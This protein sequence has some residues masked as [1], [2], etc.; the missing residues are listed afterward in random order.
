MA[1]FNLTIQLQLRAPANLAQVGKQIS[2][3]LGATPVNIPV[4]LQVPP[5]SVSQVLQQAQQQAQQASTA[6]NNMAR[7]AT[8]ATVAANN[9]ATAQARVNLQMAQSRLLMTNM[10]RQV[11]TLNQQVLQGTSYWARFGAAVSD[12]SQR[13][14]AFVAGAS[15]FLVV[16]RGIREGV[17]AAIEFE[18]QINKIAQ[19]SG[20]SDAAI[21]GIRTRIGELAQS[22]GVSSTEMSQ[23]AL[24][25]AQTGLTAKEVAENMETLAMAA[26]APNFESMQQ[27]A[28]GMIAVMRQFKL[29]SVGVKESIGAMNEV[30]A[31]FA[32][33]SRDLVTAVRKAGGAFAAAGG[34][35]NELLALFTAVR[36]TT[37][38]GAEEIA[39]G[40]RTIL[41]RTQRADVIEELRALNV[42]LR[43]TAK[44]ADAVGRSD[45]TN[46]FVGPY[47]AVK[48]LSEAIKSI[49]ATDPR[50]SSVVESLG[51]YRQISRVIPLI[52]QF[53]TAEK[54]LATAQVG[55]FS[56]YRSAEKAQESLYMKVARTREEFLELFRA[57]SETPAF[58]MFAR[59]ALSAA[60][61]VGTLL[62]TLKPLLPMLLAIGTVKLAQAFGGFVTRAISGPPAVSPKG[63]ARGGYVDGPAGHGDV[64]PARLS[65][66][67]FVVREPSVRALRKQFGDS[68]LPVI[69]ET[70]R[71][72]RFEGG[73]RPEEDP[74]FVAEMLRGVNQVTRTRK[75]GV[76]QVIG[77]MPLDM[78]MGTA[79]S[80]GLYFVNSKEELNQRHNY[81]RGHRDYP[82]HARYSE[83]SDYDGFSAQFL[84][85]RSGHVILPNKSRMSLS[86]A[87]DAIKFLGRSGILSRAANNEMLGAN[88]NFTGLVNNNSVLNEMNFRE[89]G[90][91]YEQ[92]LQYIVSNLHNPRQNNSIYDMFAR[93]SVFGSGRERVESN[94]LI[95]RMLR[96]GSSSGSYSDVSR[97]WL[98][99][100]PLR[101]EILGHADGGQVSPFK[102]MVANVLMGLSS[103]FGGDPL[104]DQAELIARKQEEQRR[105]QVQV[106]SQLRPPVIGKAMGGQI[107]RFEG[108]GPASSSLDDIVSNY[109]RGLGKK[110]NI[111]LAQYANPGQ[112]VSLFQKINVPYYGAY[113]PT[114]NS[115]AMNPAAIGQSG[116]LPPA[117]MYTATH[118]LG[119]LIDYNRDRHSGTSPFNTLRKLHRKNIESLFEERGISIF[120]GNPNN[121]MDLQPS[122]IDKLN[123][124]DEVMADAIAFASSRLLRFP[125]RQNMPHAQSLKSLKRMLPELPLKGFDDVTNH[126]YDKVVPDIRKRFGEYDPT[127]RYEDGGMAQSLIAGNALIV[128]NIRGYDREKNLL[129]IS[130]IGNE[131]LERGMSLKWHQKKVDAPGMESLLSNHNEFPFN[132]STLKN[133]L[134]TLEGADYNELM[135]DLKKRQEIEIRHYIKGVGDEAN[136]NLSPFVQPYGI[137]LSIGHDGPDKTRNYH[138]RMLSSIPLKLRNYIPY[139]QQLFGISLQNSSYF[140]P[141]GQRGYERASL[142]AISQNMTRSLNLLDTSNNPEAYQQQRGFDTDVWKYRL[143]RKYLIGDSGINFEHKLARNRAIGLS[144]DYE[145]AGLAEY[146][147]SDKMP[148]FDEKQGQQLYLNPKEFLMD[149]PNFRKVRG[150][151]DKHRNHLREI[152]ANKQQHLAFF[153]SLVGDASGNIPKLAT[154]GIVNPV[155]LKEQMFAQGGDS[156]DRIPA[157]VTPGEFIVREE[158]ARNLYPVLHYMN[159]YGKV[160]PHLLGRDGKLRGYS[161]GGVVGDPLVREGEDLTKIDPTIIRQRLEDRNKLRGNTQ[162]AK[163]DL[164]TD[165]SELGL[166]DFLA[167][168]KLS[169]KKGGIASRGKDKKLANVVDDIMRVVTLRHTNLDEF[170]QERARVAAIKSP[171]RGPKLRAA[172]R[173]AMTPEQKQEADAQVTSLDA[174]LK[175]YQGRILKA[176]RS[177]LLRY[178][179]NDFSEEDISQ[180]AQILAREKMA[181]GQFDKTRGKSKDPEGAYLAQLARNLATGYMK[182]NYI[183]TNEDLLDERGV[184]VLTRNNTPRKKWVRR[185]VS[186]ESTEEGQT[187]VLDAGA[188]ASPQS[189]LSSEFE[190][191]TPEQ[192]EKEKIEQ[193]A[194]QQKALQL[195]AQKRAENVARSRNAETIA[196][197]IYAQASNQGGQASTQGAAAAMMAAR[198]QKAEALRAAK[199]AGRVE[200]SVPTPAPVILPT[201]PTGPGAITLANLLKPVSPPSPAPEAYLSPSSYGDGDPLMPYPNTVIRRPDKKLLSIAPLNSDGEPINELMPHPAE[202]SQLQAMIEQERRTARGFTG[203]SLPIIR[204]PL[205]KRYEG[206][207]GQVDDY[208]PSRNLPVYSPRKAPLKGPSE[209]VRHGWQSGSIA[210]LEDSQ[211]VLSASG[212]GSSIPP[213]PPTPPAPPPPPGDEP[214][215]PSFAKFPLPIIRKSPTK[216]YEGLLGQTDDR[217]L[218]RIPL[219][220]LPS[221]SSLPLVRA[222][223]PIT[224]DA[225]LKAQRGS[226][227]QAS[228]SYLTSQLPPT[229]LSS[230]V[231]STDEELAVAQAARERMR[232]L[233]K[234]QIENKLAQRR[235]DSRRK[236]AQNLPYPSGD[237]RID[238]LKFAAGNEEFAKYMNANRT[239]ISKQINEKIKPGDT[240]RKRRRSTMIDSTAPPV[241]LSKAIKFGEDGDLITFSNKHASITS[242]LIPGPTTSE[243]SPVVPLA[244]NPSRLE[245]EDFGRD[246]W[247]QESDYFDGN[248]PQSPVLPTKKLVPPAPPLP[249]VPPTTVPP[250]PVPAPSPSF[251]RGDYRHILQPQPG[252]L[253]KVPSNARVAKGKVSLYGGWY[254]DAPAMNA[255]DKQRQRAGRDFIPDYTTETLAGPLA[256]PR[257]IRPVMTTPEVMRATQQQRLP[258]DISSK[259]LAGMEEASASIARQVR[260]SLYGGQSEKAKKLKEKIDNLN[261]KVLPKLMELRKAEAAGGDEKML[262]KLDAAIENAKLE[263]TK[264][265][266]KIPVANIEAGGMMAV[267]ELRKQIGGLGGRQRVNERLEFAQARMRKYQEDFEG[268]SSGDVG[269]DAQKAKVESASKD[270]QLR[271]QQKRQ[272]EQVNA[273]VQRRQA[274]LDPLRTARNQARRIA[275][276]GVS[277][278]PALSP[279][280]QAMDVKAALR[281]QNRMAGTANVDPL[282]LKA[283]LLRQI[284][285]G[286]AGPDT[287]EYALDQAK[288]YDPKKRTGLSPAQYAQIAKAYEKKGGVLSHDQ[289][290]KSEGAIDTA[291]EAANRNPVN[292]QRARTAGAR[293]NQAGARTSTLFELMEKNARAE[294]GKEEKEMM[295]RNGGQLSQTTRDE[296]HNKALPKAAEKTQRDLINAQAQVLQQLN[297]EL[298]SGEAYRMAREQVAEALRK[299]A[300]QQ[301]AAAQARAEGKT[302][303]KVESQVALDKNGDPLGLK[304]T[305]AQANAQ[306]INVGPVKP[307][308]NKTLG[309]ILDEKTDAAAKLVLDKKIA[310][311]AGHPLSQRTQDEAKNQARAN[312]SKDFMRDLQS[313]QTEALLVKKKGM[314]RNEAEQMAREQIEAA[315]R[316]EAAAAQH[317]QSGAEGPPP[318]VPRIVMGTNGKPLGLEDTINEMQATGAVPPGPAPLTWSERLGR[319]G[320]TVGQGL[321]N[322]VTERE[323]RWQAA[324]ARNG[325]NPQMAG[326]GFSMMAPYLGQAFQGDAETAVLAQRGGTY[327]AGA[328]TSGAL[329]GAAVGAM[330]GS[331]LPGMG[332]QGMVGGAALGAII[333]GFTAFRE[334]VR[335]LS[336]IKLD[337]AIGM[338]ADKLGVLAA[339]AENP[340]A[341]L[342]YRTGAIQQMQTAEDEARSM[343]EEGSGYL[344]IDPKKYAALREKAERQS[345]GPL[346]PSMIQTLQGDISRRLKTDPDLKQDGK[347]V[348][349]VAGPLL[350]KINSD[351]LD[352]KIIDRLANLKKESPQN[353]LDEQKIYIAKQ[354]RSLQ[355]EDTGKAAQR[356]QESNI[357]SFGLMANA[358]QA[359]SDSLRLLRNSAN[360]LTEAF[361][362]NLTNPSRVDINPDLLGK[363]GTG[364]P[365]VAPLLELFKNNG[366]ETGR[367]MYDTATAADRI[368][369]ELP[370]ALLAAAKT[371]RQDTDEGRTDFMT[372]VRNQMEKALG[373]Q[374][375][376]GAYRRVLD[377]S[378]ASVNQM[379]TGEKQ[380]QGLLQAVVEDASGVGRRATEPVLGPI[381]EYGRKFLEPLLGGVNEYSERLATGR[382]QGEVTFSGEIRASEM[383]LS[384]QRLRA[385]VTGEQNLTPRASLN[386]ISLAQLV[387][388]FT[389]RQA[390]LAQRAGIGG[391]G[392]SPD[393]FAKKYKELTP[394]ILA[395]QEAQRSAIIGGNPGEI[396]ATTKRLDEL[397]GQAQNAANGLRSL[398]ES[399]TNLQAIQEKI[400]QIRGDKEGRLGFAERYVTSGVEGRLE[401]QRGLLLFGQLAAKDSRTKPS[402][403]SLVPEDQALV[404]QT[405]R[406]LGGTRLSGVPGKPYASDKLQEL[407][408]NSMG[409]VAGLD[410]ESSKEMENL[411]GQ[412]L[413]EQ[414]NM[415]E[416]QQLTVKL[417]KDANKEL[418][419]GIDTFIASLFARLSAFFANEQVEA[420]EKKIIVE[421]QRQGRLVQQ[422]SFADTLAGAGITTDLQQRVVEQ[423]TGDLQQ[424]S[425]ARVKTQQII[426]NYDKALNEIQAGGYTPFETNKSTKVNMEELLKNNALGSESGNI[427]ESGNSSLFSPEMRYSAI[428][429]SLIAR[430][431]ALKKMIT[432][433]TEG[434][435][436]KDNRSYLGVMYGYDSGVDSRS[437]QLAGD[438][439][440]GKDTLDNAKDVGLD[441][442][443]LRKTLSN[444]DSASKL[445]QAIEGLGGTSITQLN[446]KLEESRKEIEALNVE[447]DRLKANAKQLQYAA[448]PP[449]AVSRDVLPPAG[450]LTNPDVPQ[451]GPA[452]PQTPE[453]MDRREPGN[454]PF[455]PRNPEDIL[456]PRRNPNPNPGALPLPTEVEPTLLPALI[457]A[458]EQAMQLGAAGWSGLGEIPGLLGQIPL[459]KPRPERLAEPPVPVRDISNEEAVDKALALGIGDARPASSL[460]SGRQNLGFE[461][462][463]RDKEKLAL[464]ATGLGG[465]FATRR[466][467][468]IGLPPHYDWTQRADAAGPWTMSRLNG[469][470]I[471]GSGGLPRKPEQLSVAPKIQLPPSLLK[472]NDDDAMRRYI[473]GAFSAADI[474][475]NMLKDDE[476]SKAALGIPGGLKGLNTFTGDY[477]KYANDGFTPGKKPLIQNY[478]KIPDTEQRF[479]ESILERPK[480]IRPEPISEEPVPG[481]LERLKVEPTQIRPEQLLAHPTPQLPYLVRKYY[482]E[483]TGDYKTYGDFRPPASLSHDNKMAHVPVMQVL[484]GKKIRQEWRSQFGTAEQAKDTSWS[485]L[486]IH[487][488]EQW[489]DDS[490][491]YLKEMEKWRA[492]GGVGKKPVKPNPLDASRYN[493]YDS[494]L[495]APGSQLLP[496]TQPRTGVYGGGNGG[497]NLLPSV[498]P[499]AHLPRFFRHIYDEQDPSNLLLNGRTFADEFT[500]AKPVQGLNRMLQ[501][502]SLRSELMAGGGASQRE[503][504]KFL[505]DYKKWKEEGGKSDARPDISNYFSF[506]RGVGFPNN[507]TFPDSFKH[508]VK[509]ADLFAQAGPGGTISALPVE[510]SRFGHEL[511]V[512]PGLRGEIQRFVTDWT[513]SKGT[514]RQKPEINDYF[515]N[516]N[517]RV[518]A[519]PLGDFTKSVNEAK[520]AISGL[521]KEATTTK[522]ALQQVTD[523]VKPK[524]G[525][526]SIRAADFTDTSGRS[527]RSPF[528]PPIAEAKAT[529][530]AEL[531]RGPAATERPARLK[532]APEATLD[533]KEIPAPQFGPMDHLPNFFKHMYD[534]V[535]PAD[536]LSSKT[537]ADEYTKDGAKK[538]LQR[539]MQNPA[540]GRVV[541]A[542]GPLGEKEMGRFLGDYEEW[543]NSQFND[544]ARADYEKKF[545]HTNKPEIGNYFGFA[546]GVA[547]PRSKST[548]AFFREIHRNADIYRHLGPVGTTQVIQ[549]MGNPI[550]SE[551]LGTIPGAMDEVKRFLEDYQKFKQG[552][553]RLPMPEMS[554]Y[555]AVGGAVGHPGSPRGTDTIPAWLTP[556]EFVVNAAS[557]AANRDL[558]EQ[559]NQARGPVYLAEGGLLPAFEFLGQ[560][561]TQLKNFDQLKGQDLASLENQ[562]GKL[563]LPQL[564]SF[565]DMLPGG[566]GSPF[567]PMMESLMPAR[568]LSYQGSDLKR[569]LRMRARMDPFGAAGQKIRGDSSLSYPEMGAQ[570]ALFGINLLRRRQ[571]NAQSVDPFAAFGLAR[572][573]SQSESSIFERA[574]VGRQAGME[575]AIRTNQDARRARR[576]FSLLTNRSSW[577]RHPAFMND[578]R[579]RTPGFGFGFGFASGGFVPSYLAMGGLPAPDNVPAYLSGGEYVLPRKV[580]DNYGLSNVQKFAEGGLVRGN[581]GGIQ[582]PAGQTSAGIAPEVL[583]AISK[584]SQF[585]EMLKTAFAGFS[586]SVNLLRNSLTGFGVAAGELANAL[587]NFSGTLQVSGT[588]R[589]ELVL[590]GADI[591]KTISGDLQKMV[592]DMVRTQVIRLMKQSMPDVNIE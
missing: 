384:L 151:Q 428:R 523:V 18:R 332:I 152:M 276:A 344:S 377:I 1:G 398:A 85:L 108:G 175:D 388:P 274:E 169:A 392:L 456:D 213:V 216:R 353:V 296:L 141:N 592:A 459:S 283:D 488:L 196:A 486:N 584:F 468:Q 187:S 79:F 113:L 575:R 327:T 72:P 389:D 252:I 547:F 463:T 209:V 358:A 435:A 154:G 170:E 484:D 472:L 518:M 577:V 104:D 509:N 118:E 502:P 426:D 31:K 289:M 564:P 541:K 522:D 451:G 294:Y 100:R 114:E 4:R 87:K 226:A 98:F 173:E 120:S 238:T 161:K 67:E 101:P 442:P 228:P 503:M 315:M 99:Q 517:A 53:A 415:I 359:A 281:Q 256:E 70:G 241:S 37:R 174:K 527:V 562:F 3:A 309:E 474:L 307:S 9:Q 511:K 54:A 312:V 395:A 28:E 545:G 356:G 61:A 97:E 298:K 284:E 407:L 222:T 55:S 273:E 360:N 60:S 314:N 589:V 501:I 572:P 427:L 361:E 30:A 263:V 147:L 266:A 150:G 558:L 498:D 262:E 264:S 193:A 585:S 24:I 119:H 394:Q 494:P 581:T 103:F 455:A 380:L 331:Y 194:I 406:S 259:E 440:K 563:S 299:E 239:L 297:R 223:L 432:P 15:A 261:K 521:S 219:S 425:A 153:R 116:Q 7:S 516:P 374:A 282:K 208:G 552:G 112:F 520:T 68:F 182:H 162:Y 279:A 249:P 131:M 574:L 431:D 550:F 271:Q 32:V 326:F 293:F 137:P 319:F 416:A 94:K 202:E 369:D 25:L 155:P 160:P 418:L 336:Q 373:E 65:A 253:G 96:V 500:D 446:A 251:P 579:M 467:D 302:V 78:F 365:E 235:S 419:A 557:A 47:E 242:P 224:L 424:Y 560:F 159:R 396:Q 410:A 106:V 290:T 91:E 513:S 128:P 17:G 313:A 329:Q 49:P 382:R 434:E 123:D 181:A 133:N 269:Y 240:P 33:E 57:I 408:L 46:Q 231:S 569:E 402:L 75:S 386:A 42:E 429:G 464:L 366:G 260:P 48:R 487:A 320:R 39:T 453:R 250:S 328:T 244:A 478:L 588:Q 217:R 479:A 295:A 556:N 14:G 325:F 84:G 364:N 409:G 514:N 300:D 350:K 180:E 480:Q 591:L 230:V 379:M 351:P 340:T 420:Q 179:I 270:L 165:L 76:S 268:M 390:G 277:V 570:N 142:R 337:R 515:T 88:N 135:A 301:K 40:L 430:R 458:A 413:N 322:N 538:G 225:E 227:P 310:Q 533:R 405:A 348:E 436:P 587:A 291:R 339:N 510:D 537:F 549:G 438:I 460:L 23:A 363:I 80:G 393:I 195:L 565:G 110:L 66:G 444:K 20:E 275:K 422:K 559:I 411:Q 317:A 26:A 357:Y 63:F 321:V 27:T 508:V 207:L 236:I 481:Y 519:T 338:L 102:G 5:N 571:L 158:S 311:N 335:E 526:E 199:A 183:Q 220:V 465:A 109:Y 535:N 437:A 568:D 576:E 506:A 414:K 186:G 136:L 397:R 566:F 482:D 450:P 493:F 536:P 354:I 555:F 492:G 122:Y 64:V 362:M 305:V 189:Y 499:T 73:G 287:M 92:P 192:I 156:R 247:K 22:L 443:S 285:S 8:A 69:N 176:A 441:V 221:L 233:A 258:G 540:L 524:S 56:L 447:L 214:P 525:W 333:G 542:A 466:P 372:D 163:D 197:E 381:Q 546:R 371:A 417:Q 138:E 13:F 246:L 286:Q 89:F 272:F 243:V 505:T 172:L 215:R 495:I 489:G 211:S 267:A 561:A 36:S 144:N 206:L 257:I 184:P 45:L 470:L 485:S 127:A 457:P 134:D 306:N 454:N 74:E 567:A 218:S 323:R 548:P 200:Q 490:N 229:T 368:R 16:T 387:K 255:A 496:N 148:F 452:T 497:Q 304:G 149:I 129:A 449:K 10:Q 288:A 265:K 58:Q 421:Q 185:Q 551:E 198:R 475:G 583:E 205:T 367:A 11:T 280:A 582:A 539:L 188:K 248:L 433:E 171:Q 292:D 375:G 345:F 86:N 341:L 44:E 507:R 146:L 391:D 139:A 157:L 111:N 403:D 117:A 166:S 355:M 34:D 303:P 376:Q 6:T 471:F 77:Q 204:K 483:K 19:V 126:F 132:G 573:D 412:L 352:K 232:E 234:K 448:S 590:L 107:P 476:L 491:Q 532:M 178:G 531:K 342:S 423:K 330:M 210:M 191:P 544:Q 12:I 245:P 41:A 553:G 35:V 530:L 212:G 477:H 308:S 145:G 324:A 400:S 334:A 177:T 254:V 461:A 445:F 528:L 378:L 50:F 349:N 51:G 62:D 130:T 81:I 529:T 534:K 237:S 580:V 347:Y 168:G 105:A 370:K 21:L 318:L 346:M 83:Y 52:Q 504:L 439:R 201:S 95:A 469:G 82:G 115:I 124:D 140:M 71:M 543:T 586:Q 473:T 462:F 59:T 43:Y 383:E 125:S 90:D 399:T 38:E 29:D 203:V 401:M 167:S 404:V 164:A 512:I 143:M 316:A 121:F 190:G 385:E 93:E 343:A 278:D 578:F 554:D 2:G